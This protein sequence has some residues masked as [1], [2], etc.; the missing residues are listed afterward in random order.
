MA[1][2]IICDSC[3]KRQKMPIEDGSY[4]LPTHWGWRTEDETGK[5]LVY[6][7]ECHEG[8]M[9]ARKEV[10]RAFWERAARYAASKE[11][12]SSEKVES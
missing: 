2:H 4:G 1:A 6:C 5:E 9:L 12:A 11:D 10:S 3:E 7:R 8:E